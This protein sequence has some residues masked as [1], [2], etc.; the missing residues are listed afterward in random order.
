MTRAMSP[1]SIAAS[2]PGKVVVS[3]EYAVLVG[4]PAL[5][6]AIDRRVVCTLR[7]ATTG[8]WLCQT[9]GFAGDVHHSLATLT[10]GATLPRTDGARMCQFVLREMRRTGVSLE[11]LPPHLELDIDSRA[12]FDGANKLGIGTSAAVCSALTGALLARCGRKDDAFAI[13]YAA[14]RAAQDGRGSGVDIAASC[15]GGL[16]RYSVQQKPVCSR[17]TF[18]RGV[19]FAAFWTGA[20]ADTRQHVARFD[21]WRADTIPQSL[22]ALVDAASLVADATTDARDFVRQLRAYAAALWSFDDIA[23]LGIFSA[24]H[25][26]L[27]RCAADH[28]VVYK[29][30]GAGGGDLGLAFALDALAIESFERVAGAA[31][32]MRLPLEL[33][34]HG[35][36]VGIE[37]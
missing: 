29:P 11:C 23:R 36:T 31:G 12:G 34:E 22:Q 17:V 35:I 3:G 13:A 10:D 24:S 16:V 5:V 20:S 27:T 21:T 32:L 26:L 2:A 1:R 9:H 37:G 18:P 28:G 15:R 8:D 7:D 14:H 6:M 4:A 19:A 25:R 30:C 33:D